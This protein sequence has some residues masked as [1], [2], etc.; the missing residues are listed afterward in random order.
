MFDRRAK[1]CYQIAMRALMH[2]TILCTTRLRLVG[3]VVR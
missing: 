2:T 3:E 1:I